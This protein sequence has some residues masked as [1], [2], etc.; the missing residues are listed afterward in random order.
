M[1]K[2]TNSLPC[3]LQFICDSRDLATLFRVN[4][5]AQSFIRVHLENMAIVALNGYLSI[6]FDSMHFTFKK[7]LARDQA[8][9]AGS[10]LIQCL[11]G[12]SWAGSDIDIFIPRS[13]QKRS[14]KSDTEGFL[15]SKSIIHTTASRKYHGMPSAP[16]FIDRINNFKIRANIP[17]AYA[18]PQIQAIRMR[19]HTSSQI[20]RHLYRATDFAICKNVYFIDACG[21]EVIHFSSIP[22]ILDHCEYRFAAQPLVPTI[23]I[24]SDQIMTIAR[25][26]KYARRGFRFAHPIQMTYIVAMRLLSQGSICQDDINDGLFII[27]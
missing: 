24:S 20:I 8:V 23:P 18:L 14:R 17:A 11:L 1:A 9:I 2:R 15:A 22:S 16:Q 3:I 6:A 13:G 7:I 12:T 5:N 26:I 4:Q 27:Q 10:F 19:Y 21:H 25:Y